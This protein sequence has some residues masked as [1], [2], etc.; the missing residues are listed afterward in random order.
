R[1][2]P[3]NKVIPKYEFIGNLKINLTEVLMDGKGMSKIT[4]S[5]SSLGNLLEK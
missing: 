4:A 2:G 3:Y 5:S 1:D